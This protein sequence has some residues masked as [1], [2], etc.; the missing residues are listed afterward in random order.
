M[1]TTEENIQILQFFIIILLGSLTVYICSSYHI[2]VVNIS[3]EYYLNLYLT[4]TIFNG[5]RLPAN[6]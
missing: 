6:S 2:T 1:T 5:D 4:K 3:D